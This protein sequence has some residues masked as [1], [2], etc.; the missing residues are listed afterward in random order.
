MKKILLFLSLSV[1]VISFQGCIK[2]AVNGPCTDKTPASELPV[3]QAYAARVVHI[4]P[5]GAGQGAKAVNQLCI[6]GTL[7]GLSEGLRLAPASGPASS[8]SS[9]A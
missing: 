1:A 3:M 9:R 4:G 8:C 2:G 5:A 6:A 7:A